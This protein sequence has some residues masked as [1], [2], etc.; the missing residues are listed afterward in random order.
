MYKKIRRKKV[1]EL[2]IWRNQKMGKG[3]LRNYWIG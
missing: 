2:K 3:K 1:G